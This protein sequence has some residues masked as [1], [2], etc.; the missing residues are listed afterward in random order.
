M[1]YQ[2]QQPKDKAATFVAI[3]GAS[4]NPPATTDERLIS[5]GE[6]AAKEFS[7][8]R[9]HILP[10]AR[11]LA[12]AKRR[13]PATKAFNDW[14][15]DSAYSKLGHQDRAALIKIGKE[16]DEHEN[17]IVK[18][19]AGTDLISPQTIWE[20]IRQKLQV[21]KKARHA[22]TVHPSYY[23][24]KSMAQGDADLPADEEPTEPSVADAK[25]NAVSLANEESIEPEADAEPPGPWSTGERFDLVLFTPSEGD[26]RY[27]RADYADLETLRKCLPLHSVIEKDAAVVV[28]TKIRDLPVI[29][30]V[31]LPL[32]GF[33]QGKRPRVLIAE[34]P[35]NP[36]V[37]DARVLVAIERGVAFSAPKGWL[38]D[39]D[40]VE[41]AERLYGDVSRSLL[42]FGSTDAS[43]WHCR[44]WREL[45]SVR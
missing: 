14:L 34:Q 16:L 40:P 3:D 21:P 2:P 42:L 19:L 30:N 20:E 11:G 32:C 17:V 15:R 28:E 4:S 33:T 36:D 38:E 44:T 39:A 12:A 1:N 5:E 35:Q 27:L 26:L 8:S 45:P 13:Y 10:M 37:T 6:T 7:R 9:E 22:P 29:V 18:F 43:G 23:D 41:I 25:P 31:L 24:S